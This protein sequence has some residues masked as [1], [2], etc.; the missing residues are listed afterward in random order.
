MERAPASHESDGLRDIA[1]W[2]TTPAASGVYLSAVD[3]RRVGEAA[4]ITGLPVNRRFAVEQLFRAAALEDD[5]DTL[6]DVLVSEVR[7]HQSAYAECD[8]TALDPWIRKAEA[9]ITR[10]L[11]MRGEWQAGSPG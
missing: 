5:L 8:A 7:A 2:L 6:F 11:Q 10:L 1:R 9:T 3:L 4:G